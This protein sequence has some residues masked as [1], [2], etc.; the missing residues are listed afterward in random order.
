MTLRKVYTIESD[1]ASQK[2]LNS[3]AED[4]CNR[5]GRVES[6]AE[7]CACQSPTYWHPR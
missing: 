5:M 2:D 3:E 6:T 4:A 1:G 7:S